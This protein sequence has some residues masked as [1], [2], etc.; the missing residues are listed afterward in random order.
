MNDMTNILAKLILT[1]VTNTVTTDN[2]RYEQIPISC[3]TPELFQGG[4]CA[5]MHGFTNGRKLGDATEKIERS[6]VEKVEDLVFTYGGRE[7]K[8]EVSRSY[9]FTIERKIVLQQSWVESPQ[10][11]ST[12]GNRG[13]LWMTNGV[14]FLQPGIT[15]FTNIGNIV[16]IKNL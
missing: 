11:L 1:L 13:T 5:V 15:I 10:T 14:G 6:T 3:P 2:A 12:N 4:I 8:T 16:T 9:A 7:F